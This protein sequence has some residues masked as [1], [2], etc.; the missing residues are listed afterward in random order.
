MTSAVY[1]GGFGAITC[2]LQELTTWL[3]RKNL[4]VR[5][6]VGI[7]ADALEPYSA[8]PE[9]REPWKAIVPSESW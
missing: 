3:V 5:D 7:A 9:G 8:Q 4:A 6:I 1:L 2:A